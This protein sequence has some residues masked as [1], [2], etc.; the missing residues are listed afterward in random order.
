MPHA[1]IGI[2]ALVLTIAVVGCSVS[3]SARAD[4]SPA[5]PAAPIVILKLDD[6][7]SSADQG[8]PVSPR[9][10]RAADYIEKN[11]LKAAFGVICYSLEEDNPAYFD[12]IKERQKRGAIEFWLHGYHNRNGEEKTGEFDQGTAAEHQAIIEKSQTLARR[13]LG[14]EF[15]A[16]GAHWSNTTEETEKAVQAVDSLKIWLCGPKDSKFYKRLSIPWTIAMEDPIFV[17]DPVKFK[18]AYDASGA[19]EPVLCLQGHADQWDDERWD[20]FTKIVEF[21]KSK[22]CRFMTPT[23]Y[24]IYVSAPAADPAKSTA[25]EK[26]SQ[27]DL[28]IQPICHSAVRFAFKGKQYYVDPAGG[29]DWDTMPKADVIFITH[30]HGDHLSPKTIDAIKKDGTL[31]FGSAAVV[32]KAGFGEAIEVGQTKN[33]LDI[34]VDA[35]PACNLDPERTKY[36]PKE[37]KDNG[38]VLVFG[39]RRVYVA[40]DTEGTPEMKALADIAIAFLPINLPYT[41]T[42]KDAADAVR[43]FKP[44]ILY[45]YHQGKA[46]PAEVKKLLADE[47]S[48]EVRVLAL[49]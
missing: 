8:G 40:G 30:E 3:P 21:L 24:L 7:I 44:R 39:D 35:V 45:P 10:R 34:T 27:G 9:W 46:D 15:T 11:N 14:F 25:I 16:F 42:P 5:K 19:A 28:E 17:P 13:R 23:E 18:A 1:L 2:A 12:W 31:I 41:M 37:R 48:I 6:V 43:A 20:G 38:Y 32:K 22:G 26:T 36:H 47:K 29:A 4:A 49:P 33:V